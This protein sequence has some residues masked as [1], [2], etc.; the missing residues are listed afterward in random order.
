MNKSTILIVED[1]QG[2]RDLYYDALTNA[3]LNVLKATN[4]KEGVDMAL[5]H[6]PA[7][8]LM[9]IVMPIMDGHKAVKKIRNDEWGK[10]V[11]II[12]LTNMSDPE[13]VIYAVEQSSEEYIIKAN[14]AIKEIVNKVKMLLQNDTSSFGNHLK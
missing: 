2:I 9:D 6:H 8:I 12:F 3:G 4:G 1:N 14:T 13:N 11:K 7:I 10:D 5:L